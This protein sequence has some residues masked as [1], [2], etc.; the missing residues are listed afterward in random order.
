[1]SGTALTAIGIAGAVGN[2]LFGDAGPVV[3]GDFVFT[4]LEVPGSITWGGQQT[5]TVHKL[6]GG[7][8]VIDV[9]GRDDAALS[10]S[11]IL[12]GGDR[13][14]RAYALDEMRIAGLPVPLSWGSHLYT[15]VIRE[16]ICEDA[17]HRGNY[18]IACEVL[19]DESADPGDTDPTILGQII[20]DV[21]A[22]LPVYGAVLAATGLGQAV[23]TSLTGL[24]TT[25]GGMATLTAGSTVG[26]SV[27]VSASAAQALAASDVVTADTAFNAAPFNLTDPIA[28]TAALQ[29]VTLYAG[30]QAAG[31]FAIGGLGRMV[32]NLSLVSGETGARASMPQPVTQ[33]RPGASAGAAVVSAGGNLY[34]IAADQL[35]DAGQWWRVMTAS[36]L[37]DPMLTGLVSL[38]IPEPLPAPATGLPD[39]LVIL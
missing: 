16:F 3:L 15:V 20:A 1:M 17:A 35:G 27:I 33:Q 24:Q 4:G 21:N 22:L 7:G 5:L 36:T 6:P 12:L 13:A 2:I 37:T 18:R 25:T 32:D 34:Q 10:W 8:R 9:M 19:R 30:S 26:A 29:S 23:Y 38:K 31:L 11:G 28:A 14:S 39:G